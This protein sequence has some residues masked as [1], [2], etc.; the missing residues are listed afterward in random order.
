M[1]E[2]GSTAGATCD[3]KSVYEKGRT[4][5]RADIMKLFPTATDEQI[6]SLL[7]Q[8]QSE[9]QSE[10]V[11]TKE[12][13][14]NA[15]KVAELQAQLEELNN[16]EL[17]DIEKM[18]K[19]IEKVQGEYE[20]AQQTIKNME[21]K[22][23]LQTQGISGDDADSF[24]QSMNSDKFDASV[25]GT[26]INNAISAKEKKDMDNTPEPNGANSNPE[27]KSEAEQIAEALDIVSPQN[28]GNIIE[29]YL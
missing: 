18:K 19:Q 6:T 29:H 4:M 2:I 26:I 25:L 20:K 17:P 16:R 28:T 12:N 14:E 11:K 3:N 9:L 10:K 27:Q 7:N 23:A 8:H 21:L 5:T 1:R 15:G 13:K 24:I 22:S